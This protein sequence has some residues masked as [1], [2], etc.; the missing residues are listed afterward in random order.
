MRAGD[1]SNLA[2]T[3]CEMASKDNF[4]KEHTTLFFFLSEP[5][6]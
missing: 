4:P 1:G 5:I 6:L 3:L 2:R